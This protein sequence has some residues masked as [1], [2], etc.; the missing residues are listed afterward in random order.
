MVTVTEA[1]EPT[2]R[3]TGQDFED[4]RTRLVESLERS[5]TVTNDRVLDALE[6]VPRH[7][8][9]PAN[10]RDQAY[11]DTPL[12]IGDGQTISAPHMV[13]IMAEVLDCSPGETILEIGTG[14]G[15]HA[16]V[17]AA[18]VGPENVYSVEYSST[19]AEA[20]R[21]RLDA[22]GYGAVSIRVGD[23][24]EGWNVN[25]PFDAAYF[26]CAIPEFPP[27]VVDQVRGGGRLLAPVGSAG[28]SLELVHKDQDGHLDRT[29]HGPVRF[30]RLRG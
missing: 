17:T 28:Q 25:A 9:V 16:A 1:D 11:A 19:L 7:E 26:T 23:G 2:D 22:L 29:D 5:G 15:Y 12:P 27:S 24:R 6:T 13:G 4:A 3:G 10:R 18:L 30:V 8:F 20:A 21:E 14:C